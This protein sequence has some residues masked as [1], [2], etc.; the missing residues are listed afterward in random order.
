MLSDRLRALADAL[1][2][3]G[4]VSFTRDDLLSMLAAAG[5]PSESSG[6]T[7]DLTVVE[8]ARLLSRAPGTVRGWCAS[9]ELEGAYRFNSREWRVPPAA[10][11]LLQRK[12]AGANTVL[13]P[14]SKS[15][16]Q[17]ADLG[18]WRVLKADEH[19]RARSAQAHRAAAG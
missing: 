2:D 3:D 10:V 7:V 16:A 5:E 17:E 1:P 19:A 12:Q 13:K 4:S 14:H 6:V 9:G 18:A 11:A 15:D 8:V